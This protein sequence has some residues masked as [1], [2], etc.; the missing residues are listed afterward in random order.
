MSWPAGCS[1]PLSISCILWTTLVPLL[2]IS[3][4]CPE[5]TSNNSGEKPPALSTESPPAT[6]GAASKTPQVN[7][8]PAENSASLGP[9]PIYEMWGAERGFE[10]Q[11]FD[12]ISGYRRIMETT[13]GGVAIC[14]FDKDGWLDAFLTNGCH[15]PLSP[16]DRETPSVIFRNRAGESFLNITPQCQLQQFGYAQGCCWGDFNADGFDDLYVGTFGQNSL[17]SN[18]GDGTFSEVK[19]D[20][21]S[22]SWTSSVACGDV[23]GDG[24]LD[25]YITNYLI[26][27]DVSPRLCPNSASPEGY[28]GCS[29]AIFDGAP[30]QLM[31]G[32]SD[33][34]FRDISTTSQI[35]E[36]P[37]KGLGVVMAD[38][39]RDGQ[40]DIYVA[41]DGEANFLFVRRPDSTGLEYDDI[42]FEAGVALNERGYAQA[43]MGI[44]VAD[45]D[46]NG[47]LDMYLTHFY[48]DTNTLYVNE[49][50]LQ[51][52]EETRKSRLG[53]A[54]R[55]MLGFGTLFTDFDN[56]GTPD[57][58]VANGH[59]DD[60]TWK[61][62]P[63]PYAMRPQ[64]FRNDGSLN[65]A[66]VTRESGPYFQDDW[67]GRGAA[68]GDLNR[69][70][71]EDLIVSHQ[72]RPSTVLINRTPAVN[73]SISL[74]LVGIQ[75]NR[76]G[77]GAVVQ[78]DGDTRVHELYGGGSYLSAPAPEIRIAL[79]GGPT[80]NLTIRWPSGIEQKLEGITA[81]E[82][83]VIEGKSARSVSTHESI[84]D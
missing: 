56:N 13:G 53:S 31:L 35:T 58:F 21:V 72:L 70:G 20:A 73:P 8:Q 74:R 55:Q 26:E 19:Q 16:E 48:G 32:Q 45:C 83:V 84:G 44:A 40:T 18:D 3:A 5:S 28:E 62:P 15:I 57:L 64:F 59:V 14:D 81:G 38:F 68:N 47:F 75:S 71:S 78:R 11:R 79:Q 25:L 34:T 67:L 76:N 60:R 42:A 7:A 27:S 24:W 22:S 52:V 63:E 82:W 4:G 77:I 10:F 41:N 49:G 9:H 33:G 6:L 36:S 66:D 65:F 54:S 30:D 69:D 29:P 46:D 12:D 23:N 80:A 39:N 2:L 51:F 1:Q 43:G 37:G 50:E 17:W 61:N